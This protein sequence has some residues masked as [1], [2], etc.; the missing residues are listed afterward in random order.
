M[1]RLASLL[2]AAVIAGCVSRSTPVPTRAAQRVGTAGQ[3]TATVSATDARLVI[4][5][6]RAARWQW[7]RSTTPQ[8]YREYAWEFVVAAPFGE[9]AARTYRFGSY[10]FKPTGATPASGALADLLAAG[11]ATVWEPTASGGSAAAWG[12]IAVEALGDSAV[13]IRITAPATLARLFAH[14]PATATVIA[15]TPEAR[16]TSVTVPITYAQP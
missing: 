13:A 11:Q 10:L 6:A 3:P 4:P 2:A 7:Y 9:G 8:D 5:V 14:R 15:L 1:R 12:Q 16:E